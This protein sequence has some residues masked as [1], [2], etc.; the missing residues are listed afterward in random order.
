MSGCDINLSSP[1]I[2]GP[3]GTQHVRDTV[4]VPPSCVIDVAA[5]C[6]TVE[7]GVWL[8]EEAHNK[9]P[10]LAVACAIVEPKSTSLPLSI[11]N[12]ST[13]PITLYAGSTIATM[14]PVDLSTE[15]SVVDRD[16]GCQV[17]KEKQQLAWQLAQ[18]SCAALEPGE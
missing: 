10:E 11:L 3:T 16:D 8:V 1:T 2:D 14:S 17:S 12:T 15:V 18:E 4:K 5:V 9:Y 7:G 13:L 6:A